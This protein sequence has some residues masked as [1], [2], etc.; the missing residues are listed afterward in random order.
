MLIF[1]AILKEVTLLILYTAYMNMVTYGKETDA[2]ICRVA[3]VVLHSPKM[4]QWSNHA[5]M[6]DGDHAGLLVWHNDD[7]VMCRGRPLHSSQK[8]IASLSS[9]VTLVHRIAVV[10]LHLANSTG[11]LQ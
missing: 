3:Q 4:C 9:F 7:I 10:L 2:F 1:R 6:S 8:I 5:S 11:L